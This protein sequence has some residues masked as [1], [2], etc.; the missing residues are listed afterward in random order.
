MLKQLKRGGKNKM[1]LEKIKKLRELT[2]AGMVDCQQALAE[3]DNDLDK[4]EKILRK[5]GQKMA[6]KKQDREVKEGVIAV[7]STEKK[8]AVVILLCETDFVAKNESFQAVAQELADKLLEVGESDFNTWAKE[9]IQN[10]LIVKIGE[11]LQLGEAKII[12]GEILGG[13]LHFNKKFAGVVVLK[14][15]T[16]ELA[17]ELAMQVVA[18]NPEYLSPEDVPTA[19]TD[20][21]KEIYRE[22]LA[23]ENKPPEIIEKILVGKL[24]KFYSEVCLL[25]QSYIKDEDKTI[26]QLIKEAGE[27]IKIERFSRFSL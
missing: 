22:Q 11:N 24:E 6:I 15:G 3:A 1:S 4:A 9:K 20:K 16:A 25:K 14:N 27:D 18:L 12:E 19:V 2:G 5:K 17:K 21:E 8:V 23:S 7:A 10:E 13:Y 26:E